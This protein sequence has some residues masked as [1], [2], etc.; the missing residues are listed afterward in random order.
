MKCLV[1]SAVWFLVGAIA[2]SGG[3]A[4]GEPADGAVRID[5]PPV[6][7]EGFGLGGFTGAGSIAAD[8]RAAVAPASDQPLPLDIVVRGPSGRDAATPQLATEIRSRIES[9]GVSAGVVANH[10]SLR[11]GFATWIGGMSLEA[12]REAG[13][14]L[15][16]LRTTLS[17][18]QQAGVLG[19][20][21]GPRIERRLRRG[22]VLFF[23]GKAQ[24]TAQ[25]PGEA[26][27]S[28]LQGPAADSTVGVAARTGLTR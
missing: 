19:I 1:R 6:V 26:G 4:R 14:D 17:R 24:A 16:E 9:L 11:D 13:R 25:Q 12:E 18:V 2:A 5:P 20:E 8:L 15:L 22:A 27:G 28:L 21:V 3:M 10:A 7:F 23:D